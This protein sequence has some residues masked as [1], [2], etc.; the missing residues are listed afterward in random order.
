MIF[1]AVFGLRCKFVLSDFE[2]G[3][4]AENGKSSR[5]ILL[6]DEESTFVGYFFAGQNV[7]SEVKPSIT[8]GVCDR[9]DQFMRKRTVGGIDELTVRSA[10]AKGATCNVLKW[11]DCEKNMPNITKC[12]AAVEGTKDKAAG[13]IG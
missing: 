8:I 2:N 1:V 9:F 10:G 13:N 4:I 6:N 5:R 7:R 11:L 12:D 3:R